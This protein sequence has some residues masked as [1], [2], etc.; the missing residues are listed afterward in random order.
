MALGGVQAG[1]KNSL[2]LYAAENNP[3]WD[4][5]FKEWLAE[6]TTELELALEGSMEDTISDSEGE[7]EDF[8]NEEQTEAYSA[9]KKEWEEILEEANVVEAMLRQ[10]MENGLGQQKE[11]EKAPKKQKKEELDNDFS[12]EGVPLTDE[13]KSRNNAKTKESGGNSQFLKTDSG[14]GAEYWNLANGGRKVLVMQHPNIFCLTC[15]IQCDKKKEWKIT[16]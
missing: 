10:M 8:Q 11:E 7:T 13:G 4:S 9:R 6:L 14:H 2:Y 16:E 12:L 15:E 1:Y 5:S 3:D